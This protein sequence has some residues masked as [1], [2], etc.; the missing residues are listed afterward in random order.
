[1]SIPCESNVIQLT[2]RRQQLRSART[3]LEL[4]GDTEMACNEDLLS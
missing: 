4:D 2:W 3:L 1:M